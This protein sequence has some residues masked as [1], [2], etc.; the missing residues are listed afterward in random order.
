MA[1][2]GLAAQ[3]LLLLRQVENRH[4]PILNR[5][6]YTF[7]LQGKTKEPQRCG[8]FHILYSLLGG[9]GFCMF[10]SSHWV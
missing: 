10:L 5:V 8:S 7:R 3:Q 1:S 6:Y 4:M 9:S 2:F